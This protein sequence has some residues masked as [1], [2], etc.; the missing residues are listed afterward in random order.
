MR[1][2]ILASVISLAAIAAAHAQ[3]FAPAACDV[4]QLK[5]VYAHYQASELD[6]AVMQ[7]SINAMSAEIASLKKQVEELKTKSAPPPVNF[8]KAAKPHSGGK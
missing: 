6:K 1:S 8:S 3:Q 7:K 2:L 5:A 4:D